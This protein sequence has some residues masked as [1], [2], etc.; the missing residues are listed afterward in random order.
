MK[1]NSVLGIA[2]VMKNEAPYIIEWLAHHRLLGIRRFFI[3]NNES[4]DETT[5]LLDALQNA[6]LLV[7]HWFPTPV[8]EKPHVPALQMLIDQHR[9]DVEWVALIDADEF[10]TPQDSLFD[11]NDYLYRFSADYQGVGAI[12]INW[13]VYGSSGHRIYEPKLLAHRFTRHSDV[14]HPVNQAY[15]SI[16]K[17]NALIKILSP[18]HAQLKKGFH[19]RHGDGEALRHSDDK[20]L[21]TTYRECRSQ[22]T[23]WE[24]IRI[25]HYVIKSYQEFVQRKSPRGRAFTSFPLDNNFFI[26]HDIN[27]VSTQ[28]SPEY[29][30]KLINEISTIQRLVKKSNT[31]MNS[32]SRHQ[33][34]PPPDE[35]RSPQAGIIDSIEFTEDGLIRIFGWALPWKTES[36]S[37]IKARVNNSDWLFACSFTPFPRRD[38]LNHYPE[39]PVDCGFIAY[40]ACSLTSPVIDQLEICAIN[41]QGIAT[42]PIALGVLVQ[43][44]LK[45]QRDAL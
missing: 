39:A 5:A 38:V 33:H 27:S 25:N 24:P 8:G 31:K 6:E 12:A 37:S 2:C 4:T 17:T 29:L 10:I 11:L 14:K 21:K 42:E 3:A 45:G 1:D 15:K 36:A 32:R 30:G 40:I 9:Y 18:H 22:H 23:S 35:W 7:H 28:P 26:A 43:A 19:Y 16:I 41:H 34:G 44:M 20:S 13:S